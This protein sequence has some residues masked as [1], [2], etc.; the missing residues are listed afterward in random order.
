MRSPG[1]AEAGFV[2]YKRMLTHSD[3]WAPI[4]ASGDTRLLAA[5]KDIRELRHGDGF[6]RNRNATEPGIN[7][8]YG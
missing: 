2:V 7:R 3:G 8:E 4:H 1:T 5:E 6:V